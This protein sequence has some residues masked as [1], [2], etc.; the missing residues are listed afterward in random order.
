MESIALPLAVPPAALRPVA[1]AAAD[2]MEAMDADAI[3][4]ASDEQKK[5]LAKDFESVLLTKLF[6]EVKNS[7]EDS[8]FDDD[9][10]S[11]QVHSMFWSY[12]AQDVANKGGFGLWQDLYQQFRAMEGADAGGGSVNEEF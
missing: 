9:V 1:S 2:P 6:E 12:L 3:R 4:R 11:D 5:Q 10:A 7:I 8:G